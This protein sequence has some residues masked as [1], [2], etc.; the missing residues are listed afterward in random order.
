MEEDSFDE[1]NEPPRRSRSKKRSTQCAHCHGWASGG[2]IG[3]F[4]MS[5]QYKSFCSAGCRTKYLKK[6]AEQKT[7]VVEARVA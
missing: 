5:G 4:D 6:E 1:M 3:G 2:G 7:P